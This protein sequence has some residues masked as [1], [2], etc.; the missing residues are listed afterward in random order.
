MC[1]AFGVVWFGI[2]YRCPVLVVGLW[3]CACWSVVE[4]WLGGV[5]TAPVLGAEE[6][7]CYMV[8]MF[9]LAVV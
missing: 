4:S 1:G 2:L 7:L 3:L 6:H 5:C 9:G 8:G